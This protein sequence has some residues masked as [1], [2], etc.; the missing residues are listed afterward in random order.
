MHCTPANTGMDH[1]K[2]S[3]GEVDMIAYEDLLLIYSMA[4]S[5]QFSAKRM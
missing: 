5:D 4:M 2:H 3:M 1:F